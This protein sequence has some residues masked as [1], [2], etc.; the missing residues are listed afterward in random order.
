MRGIKLIVQV[1][2]QPTPE[3]SEALKC[4]LETANAACNRL[5][6][7][8]FEV[9]EFRRFPLQR[10]FYKPIR[11]A[12][13]LTA[14]I[15]VRLIAK[16]SDAYALDQKRKR[17]FRPHGSIS[18]DLRVLSWNMAKESVSIWSVDGRLSI[19]FVCGERQREML[20]FQRGETDLVFRDG[21]WFLFTAVDVP[22]ERESEVLDWIGVDLGIVNIATTSDGTK[23]AGAKTNGRRARNARLRKKLQ[24]KGTKSAKRLLRKRGRKERRFAADVNHCISKQLVDVAKRTGRGI[25]M[26]D[27]KGIRA[28]VRANKTQ[29]RRLHSWAFGQLQSF[30]VYKAKRAGVPVRFVEARGTSQTCPECGCV[31][32]RNRRT[33]DVF[34]CV[35]CGHTTCA[36]ANAS[37]NIRRAAVNL[38]NAAGVEDWS[39]HERAA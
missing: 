36:D 17:T 33:R 35:S 20:A 6:S 1:K 9:S 12:F 14:Q 19:P 39:V 23:F 34:R 5:S 24:K 16:V 11:E 15:V 27:L 13:P 31:D 28:R 2:L 7:L 26:E 10:L 18:Y 8:A 29:R 32:K 38:P 37:E 22:E 21:N 30:V 4:T 3:Q 25:S